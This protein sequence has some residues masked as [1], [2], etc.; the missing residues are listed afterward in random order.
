MERV[1]PYGGELIQTSL[2]TED[3]DRLRAALGEKAGVA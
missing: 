1:T 2:D 3:E